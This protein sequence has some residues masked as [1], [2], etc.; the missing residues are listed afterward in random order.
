MGAF[1]QAVEDLAGGL[2]EVDPGVAWSEV[3]THPSQPDLTSPRFRSVLT[4]HMAAL[5]G[6]LQIGPHPV[7][8]PA[9]DRPEDVLLGHEQRYWEQTAT[10]HQ[11][12]FY[13]DTLRNAVAAATVC[14]AAT[15]SQALET[16][17]R[18]PGLRDQPED[19]QFAIAS[20]LHDL[21]PTNEGHYW[22]SLQPDRLGEYL[23]GRVV[24]DDPALLGL[25]L[26][27]AADSS[28]R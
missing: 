23:I 2:A 20:W 25:L 16:V 8:A 18:V 4:V 1:S 19:R 10:A 24:N 15:R 9:S 21:Y 17:A 14:G 28:R 13:P 27:D 11:L 7:T 26:A 5:T 6:L 22:G 3:A 12:T